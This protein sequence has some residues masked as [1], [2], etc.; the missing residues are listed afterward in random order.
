[1]LLIVYINYKKYKSF[2][3]TIQNTFILKPNV[4]EEFL[5]LSMVKNLQK[6][7]KEKK[8]CFL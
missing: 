5:P 3:K 7:K 2:I 1:M 6:K 8:S 4:S